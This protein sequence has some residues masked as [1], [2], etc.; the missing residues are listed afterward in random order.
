MADVQSKNVIQYNLVSFNGQ[1]GLHVTDAPYDITLATVQEVGTNITYDSTKMLLEMGG[2]N[3]TSYVNS[4][5]S[6]VIFSSTTNNIEDYLYNTLGMVSDVVVSRIFA[7]PVTYELNTTDVLTLYVGKVT[8]M[9]TT[10]NANTIEIVV[11]IG[12]DLT[13][14]EI[15]TAKFTTDYSQVNFDNLTWGA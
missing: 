2:L 13:K 10:R 5:S 11:D 7:D 15:I 3:S 14:F 8:G 1:A 6:Q 9:R 4:T 12:N